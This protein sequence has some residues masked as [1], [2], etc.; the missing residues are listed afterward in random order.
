M[1]KNERQTIIREIIAGHVI[2]THEEIASGLRKS[3]I[4]ATQATISRD[5]VK[6]GI[7]KD[8]KSGAYVILK[9]DVRDSEALAQALNMF[10]R[11][12]LSVQN[13]VII[14]TDP[15]AAQNVGALIDLLSVPEIIGTVAGDDT[16]FAAVA[17]KEKATRAAKRLR[18]ALQ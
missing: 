12:I 2:K 9:E 3:G 6:L 7:T 4:I 11:E 5:L 8:R 14:K 16:I 17:T 13:M 15:G 1:N 18:Q 10:V